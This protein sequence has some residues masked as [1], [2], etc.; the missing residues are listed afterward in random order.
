LSRASRPK[1]TTNENGLVLPLHGRG[2]DLVVGAAHAVELELAHGFEDL[3]TL[4]QIAL[5][6]LS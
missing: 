5:L 1:A 4:H 3:R 2:D 6:R